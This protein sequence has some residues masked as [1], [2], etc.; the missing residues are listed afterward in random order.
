MQYRRLEGAPTDVSVVGLDVGAVLARGPRGGEG[1][2]SALI[3]AAVLIGVDLFDVADAPDPALALRAIEDG[4][5]ERP[6]TAV[7]PV[8]DGR[9]LPASPSPSDLPR[10]WVELVDVPV[11]PPPAPSP[12]WLRGR[13]FPPRDGATFSR[14]QLLAERTT[15]LR[16]AGSAVDP[17]SLI[18]AAS[19]A[20]D[21]G[22][23]IVVTDPHGQ[24]LL[25][26]RWLEGSLAN[27]PRPAPPE[28]WPQLRDR[29]EPV[30]RL[31]PLTSGRGRS[32]AQSAVQFALASPRVAAVLVAPTVPS[33]I[34]ELAHPEAWPEFTEADRE[35]VLSRRPERRP[36]VR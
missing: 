5:R 18:G 13:R 33:Q 26:G 10:T 3:R 7:V 36:G 23:S 4:A 19:L 15:V 34:A 30:T 21:G 24:G 27:Q 6:Y 25:D 22:I 1:A 8:P 29:L 35:R 14:E 16:V 31:A 11:K 9:A 17:T 12:T 2:I 20:G 32:L 28:P